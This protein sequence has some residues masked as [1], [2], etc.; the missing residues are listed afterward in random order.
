[1]LKIIFSVVLGAF[2][3]MLWYSPTVGFGHAWASNAWPGKTI[4]EIGHSN[5]ESAYVITIFANLMVM[6]LFNVILR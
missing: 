2:I 4:E 1:M 3:G 5:T 6:I